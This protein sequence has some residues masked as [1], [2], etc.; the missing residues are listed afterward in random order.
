[1][2]VVDVVDVVADAVADAA[3]R[4]AE[5]RSLSSL[6]DTLASSW[7]SLARMTCL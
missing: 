4:A 7:P 3:A 6:T 1:V 2:V 5:R